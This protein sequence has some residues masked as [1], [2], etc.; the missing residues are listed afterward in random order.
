[1]AAPA[2]LAA[3][4]PAPADA[5]LPEQPAKAAQAS[6]ARKRVA[7][8]WTGMC[9]AVVVV[10][11]FITVVVVPKPPARMGL[12]W[13]QRGDSGLNLWEVGGIMANALAILAGAT[14]VQDAL[15]PF[16]AAKQR[17]EKVRWKPDEPRGPGRPAQ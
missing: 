5:G 13:P 3:A 7:L 10:Y 11:A 4:E 9:V 6:P 1:M 16:I 8:I 14:L 2:S 12:F 17:G 15:W